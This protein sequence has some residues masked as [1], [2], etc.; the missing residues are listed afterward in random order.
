MD[1]Y[2]PVEYAYF[3]NTLFCSSCC[4]LLITDINR[5]ELEIIFTSSTTASSFGATAPILALAYLRQTL[6]FT[7]VY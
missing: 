2:T 7:S 5:M 3:P 6:R 1:K 4:V